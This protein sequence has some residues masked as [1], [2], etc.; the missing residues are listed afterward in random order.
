MLYDG[1]TTTLVMIQITFNPKH[2]ICYKEIES[3]LMNQKPIEKYSKKLQHYKF[4]QS[5]KSEKLVT[6]YCYQ[7][8]TDK[9]YPELRKQL[10]DEKPK[11]LQV[12][13]CYQPL[14]DEINRK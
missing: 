7:W 11:N 9:N 3:L 2:D 4:L 1:K 8:M 5:L 13:T 10:E 6:L 14:I 12:S